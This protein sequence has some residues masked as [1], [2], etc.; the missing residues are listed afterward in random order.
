MEDMDRR[1]TLDELLQRLYEQERDYAI[2]L[3]DP[4]GR[5]LAWLGGSEH[6]LGFTPDEMLGQP[7]A[8]IFTPED[9]EQGSDELER[10]EAQRRG[11][12]DDDR[13]HLRRDGVRIWVS[14]V[15]VALRGDQGQ[16]LGYAKILRDRTDLKGHIETLE[17]R[18]KVLKRSDE[19][20]DLFLGTLAHELRNPLMPL[21]SALH[22]I[23]AA[24]PADGSLAYAVTLIERQ[25]ELI[26]RLVDDLM[27]LTRIRTGKIQLRQELIRLEDVLLEVK[28]AYQPKVESRR[29]TL[30]VL[31]PSRPVELTADRDRLRQVFSNLMSNAVKYTPPGGSI[32]VRLSLESTE[33]VVRVADTGIGIPGELL[34]KIFELFTQEEGQ[35]ERSE[36]G[37]G[38]GLAV[39]H[40]LVTLHGGS[41]QVRSEGRDRGCEMT[42][43]LPLPEVP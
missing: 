13:W 26:R 31:L 36:G 7:I 6:I 20:K 43:R 18:I 33:A 22:L 39:V 8:A 23:Q 9:L 29:Q 35:R 12:S 4:E 16:I 37:L 10:E 30:E 3:L 17:N 19:Q 27:D 41:V 40:E 15:L 28:A 24:A 34:P 25:L 11:R 38:I 2:I 5:I 42:V 1:A 14:G 21:A 32:W